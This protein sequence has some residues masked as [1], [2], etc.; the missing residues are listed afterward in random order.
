MSLYTNSITKTRQSNIITPKGAEL[1]LASGFSPHIENSTE[2]AIIA[3]LK[4]KYEVLA[5]KYG[6]SPEE[7]EILDTLSP[8]TRDIEFPNGVDPIIGRTLGFIYQKPNSSLVLPHSKEVFEM[9]AELKRDNPEYF[10]SLIRVKEDYK[11][12]GIGSIMLKYAEYNAAKEFKLQG[13]KHGF[14]E[15]H[16]LPS[17]ENKR[18]ETEK[19]YRN[20]GFELYDEELFKPINVEQV[21]DETSSIFER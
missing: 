2:M 8:S 16:F 1:N 10:L 12:L 13:K 21:L 7:R 4:N 17:N 15:G 18:V 5:Q 11:G 9:L 20:N 6:F 14:I 19:F 3:H